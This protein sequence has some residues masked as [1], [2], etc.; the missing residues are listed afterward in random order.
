[1]VPPADAGA[2]LQPHDH[3]VVG[4]IQL[5]V[6]YVEDVDAG[7][8]PP[9]D[10]ILQWLV[11]SPYWS[12]LDE[13]DVYTGT[14][15]GSVRVPTS[16]LLDPGDV[17]GVTGLVDVL[18][19]DARIAR[20]LHGD[21]DAGTSAAV[22]LPGANAYLIYLPTGINVAIGHRGSYTYQTCIDA[23]GYHAFDGQEPYVVL[24]PCDG[25]RTL[26]AASHELIELATDPTPYHGWA[27]DIDIPINGG[28]VAD[29]CPEQVMQE[30][31]IVTRMWSNAQVRCI[32]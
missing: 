20:M 6:V 32:P 9:T 2:R 1:M 16:V 10:P 27:S 26:Y 25:G 24:P 13:Y 7:G 5:G 11:A 4:N 14:L 12:L 28:E 17:D 8:A 23:D 15:A 29:L 31:V 19:L 22:T 18:L 30:G 21:A 3:L